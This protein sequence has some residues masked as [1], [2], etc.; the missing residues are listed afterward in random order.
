MEPREPREPRTRRGETFDNPESRATPWQDLRR[1]LDQMVDL[2]DAD[3]DAAT[4]G[5]FRGNR[6]G[7]GP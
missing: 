7:H 2:L 1:V 3:A 4:A 5:G 6:G